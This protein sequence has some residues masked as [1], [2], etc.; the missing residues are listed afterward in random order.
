MKVYFWSLP[1]SLWAGCPPPLSWLLSLCRPS[2]RQVIQYHAFSFPFQHCLPCSSSLAYSHIY[3]LELACQA[4]PKKAIWNLGWDYIE[5]IDQFRQINILKYWVKNIE[6]SNPKHGISLHLFR[7]FK[8]FPQMLYSLQH[9]NLTLF[10][11][12]V[13]YFICYFKWHCKKSHFQLLISSI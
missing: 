1:L 12:N 10:L 4:S 5:S 11:L 13:F 9:T 3:I 2:C 6:S 7:S 8:F